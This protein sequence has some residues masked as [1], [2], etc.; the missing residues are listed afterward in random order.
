MVDHPPI[1]G[2]SGS[3]GTSKSVLNMMERVREAGGIPILLANHGERSAKADIAKV[4]AMIFMGNDWDVDPALYG[5]EAHPKTVNELSTPA[6]AARAKYENE[7]M[8]LTL[9]KKIPMLG[10]CA[11]LQRLNVLCGGTLHQHIPDLQ[12]VQP[13]HENNEGQPMSTPVVPVTIASGTKMATIAGETTSLYTPGVTPDRPLL[14]TEAN[15]YHHQAID[16]VASGFVVSA[17]SDTYQRADGTSDR[18]IEAIEPDPKGKFAG[19]HIIAVQWHPEFMP[20][21]PLT[22]KLVQ[23]IVKAGADHAREQG[24]VYP[25]AN[26]LN[27]TITIENQLSG[28][29]PPAPP[30]PE[31]KPGQ[32][33]VPSP[34]P[35]NPAIPQPAQSATR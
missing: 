10:V 13:G 3:K 26:M 11:G 16:R 32:A 18:L 9:D 28:I 4:D 35:A 17:T 15:S 22:P 2:I 34:G 14:A 7:L 27:A 21:N 12:G 29:V 1:I 31:L 8:A 25:P 19:Q 6:S 30:P 24:R 20:S 23:D 33:V 5:H